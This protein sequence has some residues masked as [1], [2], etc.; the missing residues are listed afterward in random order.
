[1]TDGDSTLDHSSDIVR[2][3]RS[4]REEEAEFDLFE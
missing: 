2:I 1:M 3:A 4:H